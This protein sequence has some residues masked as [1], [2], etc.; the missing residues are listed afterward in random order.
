MAKGSAKLTL[1][2]GILAAI[3]ASICCVGPLVLLGVGVSGAWIANLTTLEPMRP[4]LI[5]LTALF[6]GAAFL[7]LYRPSRTCAPDAL[8]AN[9]AILKRQRLI[10]WIVS[11]LLL[12]LLAVPVLAPYFY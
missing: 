9:P 12:G 6:L 8:C 2:A 10:F 4:W 5:G 3:G 11:M 7:S 1:V